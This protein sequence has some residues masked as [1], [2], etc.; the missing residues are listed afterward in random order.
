MVTLPCP[1]C[2]GPVIRFPKERRSVCERCHSDGDKKGR[3]IRYRSTH[4]EQIRQADKAAYAVR[5]QAKLAYAKAY[6]AAHR[7]EILLKKKAREQATKICK[8]EALQ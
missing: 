1:K 8:Q 7:D 4:R 2:D 6:Y 3:N 5:K